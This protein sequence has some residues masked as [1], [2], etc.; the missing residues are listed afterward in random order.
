[1]TQ[2]VHNALGAMV[3]SQ[4]MLAKL[5]ALA[6]SAKIIAHSRLPAHG[7][8]FPQVRSFLHVDPLS[9]S[10]L[11]SNF[12]PGALRRAAVFHPGSELLAVSEAHHILRRSHPDA[13]CICR[14]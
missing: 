2:R 11:D 9:F 12:T 13:H 10:H 4:E 6:L 1:V 3:V 14:I 8:R 7:S 5:W